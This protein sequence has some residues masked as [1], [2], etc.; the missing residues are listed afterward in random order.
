M[1]HQIR[2]Q[3]SSALL[4]RFHAIHHSAEHLGVEQALYL[5]ATLTSGYAMDA[6]VRRLVDEREIWIIFAVNP[7]GWAYDISGGTYQYWRKNRQPNGKFNPG[8]DLNRN[9]SYMWGCCEASSIEPYTWNYRGPY[10]FSAPE[11]KAVADFVASRVVQGKQQIRTHVTLHT[12]GELILYPYSYT[13][14]RLP[15]DMYPD[16]YAVFRAMARTMATMN[17]YT[18]E[19]SSQLYPSDGDEIDWLYATYRIFSF[20]FE[21]YPTE[22]AAGTK[23]IVYVSDSVIAKQTARNRGALLYLID[24]A[25]CPYAAIGRAAEYCSDAPAAGPSASP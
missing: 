9:Y 3:H 17:G 7:D 1:M 19:Q 21:L 2:L 8:T 20:T 24:A 22:K 23:G 6:Q 13:L 15:I 4:W 10:P 14:Q 25:A 18:A 5:L 11:T 16:D 12:N